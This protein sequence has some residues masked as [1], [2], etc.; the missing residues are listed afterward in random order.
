MELKEDKKLVLLLTIVYLF[1]N[2]SFIFYCLFLNPEFKTEVP[3]QGNFVTRGS[4]VLSGLLPYRDFYTNAAPLSPYIWAFVVFVSNITLIKFDFV[5]RIF[6]SFCIILSSLVLFKIQEN[7]KNKKS[8]LLS[9][10]YG[11]NPYFLYLTIVWGSD[12]CILPLLILISIYLFEKNKPTLGVICIAVGSGIKYYPIL[13]APLIWVYAKDWK[14]RILQFCILVSLLSLIFLPFYFLAPEAFLYQFKDPV[15]ETFGGNQGILSIIQAFF[16]LDLEKYNLYFKL[17]TIFALFIVGI[18]FLFKRRNNY[19]DAF[20]F[21]S[22]FLI[23][24][25]KF[26]ISYIVLL[27]PFLIEYILVEKRIITSVI[28]YTTIFFYGDAANRLVEGRYNSL[29]MIICSWGLVMLFYILFFILI[30]LHFVKWKVSS[31]ELKD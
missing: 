2:I 27:F 8:F 18:L 4:G 11:L 16:T 14:K 3:D 20:P 9:L 12:E 17:Q 28:F 10:L 31:S 13:L 29:I 7:K 22:I 30:I 23:F 21:I 24:Y 1:L 25:P 19:M 5:V 15:Q 6:F 26:Q